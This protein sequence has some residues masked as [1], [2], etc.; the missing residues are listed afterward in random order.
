MF[1]SVSFAAALVASTSANF[2]DEERQVLS[3][4]YC[5]IFFKLMFGCQAMIEAINKMEGVK[6]QA[7][8]NERFASLPVQGSMQRL[9]GVHSNSTDILDQAVRDGKVVRKSI[10]PKVSHVSLLFLGEIIFLAFQN[11]LAIPVAFDSATQWPE[12]AKVIG[13]IRDQSNCGNTLS[14][15]PFNLISLSFVTNAHASLEG[16][17]WA[18][19][20]AEAASDRL[21]IA[22]KGKT[23]LAL[24]AQDECFCASSDGCNG[25]DVFTPWQYLQSTGLVTGGQFNGLLSPQK[26]HPPHNLPVTR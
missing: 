14:F 12:C 11:G 25:G 8:H 3:F 18:F 13:D 4:P 15:Y 10:M 5:R 22:T 17:C 6:W 19:A 26:K 16:C 23:L 9:C 1:K 2:H 21:C 20:A 7:G 24:S